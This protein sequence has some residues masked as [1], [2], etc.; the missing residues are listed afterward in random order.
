MELKRKRRHDQPELPSQMRI[1]TPAHASEQQD[2]TKFDI[3]RYSGDL[4][5]GDIFS[6]V[7]I[8]E[9]V[10]NMCTGYSW[11]WIVRIGYVLDSNPLTRD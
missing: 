6:K 10:S 8:V 5:V 1:R 3:H 9:I 11:T 4:Q 2:E 7:E